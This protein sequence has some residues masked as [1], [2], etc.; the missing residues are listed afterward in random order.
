M[1]SRQ[2][3]FTVILS[4]CAVMVPET[5]SRYVSADDQIQIHGELVD[6]TAVRIFVNDNK[7][8]DGNVSLLRG[9]GE[10]AGT[11]LGKQVNA[12]CSTTGGRKLHATTCLVAVAGERVRLR[13]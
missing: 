7:V 12:D 6:S 4:G 11:Y 1:P 5:E 13:L 10:F 2:R 3:A 9:D 8:I